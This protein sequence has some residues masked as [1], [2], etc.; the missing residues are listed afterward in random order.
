MLLH[1]PRAVNP[2]NS[3]VGM[4]LPQ[5]YIPIDRRWAMARGAFLVDRT[6]GAALFADISG[7]TLLTDALVRFLGPQRGAEELPRQLNRVYDTVIA[8]VER[9]GGS[10]VGFSGDAITCWF[11]GDT[12]L[13]AAASGLA[14]QEAMEQFR[15]VSIPGGTTVELAIK[16]AVAAG[17]VRRFVV[18]SPDIQLLDVLAG[19][20][21]DRLAIAEHCANR[22]DVVL[23][24]VANANITDYISV[25]K[26]HVNQAD[27]QR[28]AVI[29][30][31][32]TDVPPTPWP[33]LE[34]DTLSE[35]LIRPWL[36]P[37][38][39]DRL[40]SGLGEFLTE[41]RPAVALFVQFGGIDFDNDAFARDKLDAYIRWVQAIL[42]CYG[43]FLIQLT[44]GDKGSYLYAAF[45][46]PI[47]HSD[48]VT[49][50]VASALE[51]RSPPPQLAFITSVRIGVSAGRMRT[52]SYGS[53]TARTYGVLGPEV[54][55][56]ARLM[57]H[58]PSHQVLVS[59]L[60]RKETGDA[61][62]WEELPA[63]RVKGKA[64]PIAV[65]RL[66]GT[67]AQ[68]GV[69]LQEPRY[70]LPIVGRM[71]ELDTVEQRMQLALDQQGQIIALTAEAGM[72]KSRLVAEIIHRASVRGLAVYAGECQSYGTN[73]SYLVWE[74][75]LQVFFGLDRAA[76]IDE[77]V[78]TLEAQLRAIDPDLL[79]RL[80][81]LGMALNLP[82]PDNDLTRS[83]DAKL[84][85]ASLEAL[86]VD[87]VRVRALSTP[88]LLVLE[89]CHWLDPLSHDLLEAVGRAITDVPV[90]IVIAYRPPEVER[91]QAPRVT[92]LVH[93]TVIS[94][95]SFT[96][97]E[98]A[99][100]V[101]LK[102]QQRSGSTAAPPPALIERV[103]ER[104]EGNPFYIEELLNYLYDR[105]VDPHDQLAL[106]QLE[107]PTSLHRL[108][109]SRIDQL[110]E[111]QKLT[112]KVASIIGRLFRLSWLWGVHPELGQRDLVLAD[113][114]SL[115]H[116]DLTPLDQPEPEFTYLFKHIITREVAYESLSFAT[117]ELLHEQ[118]GWFI[119][120]SYSDALDQYIDLL[121]YHYDHSQ[122]VPKRREYLGKAG[123]A[124]QSSFAN[125]AAID[126]YHRL[127]PLLTES[128]Q[129]DVM[130]KLGQVMELIGKWSEA[131]NLY[132]AALE[133]VERTNNRYAQPRCQRAMGELLKKQG[134]Y[135]A[136]AN[137]LDQ[138]RRGFDELHDTVGMGQTFTEIGE[139]YRL[140]GQYADA[141]SSYE[142][143][144]SLVGTADLAVR[145]T[146]LKS[147]GT[148]AWQQG[149]YEAADVFYNESLA[150]HSQ[151]KDKPGIAN[152]LSN[153]GIVAALQNDLASAGNLFNQS[154]TIRRELGDKQGIA[155]SLTNLG[156]VV[157]YQG[158]YATAR[159]LHQ[160][161]LDLYRQLGT[162]KGIADSLTNLANA[163]RDAGALDAARSFYAEAL[164]I[165]RELG[166]QWAIACLL[167]DMSGLAVARAE[168]QQA[169]Q[170]VGAASKLRELIE[171]PLS[172]DEQAKLDRVLEPARKTMEQAVFAS[173]WAEG[174]SLQMDQIVEYVRSEIV[175]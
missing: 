90:L 151:L 83:L 111:S 54:N 169:V 124:A 74:G 2:Y 36:L 130:L 53:S 98:A 104:A 173:T 110:T 101:G 21:I 8:Q 42:Q 137:W 77:Q 16:V 10:V 62:T 48:D 37:A 65:F 41:L 146:A 125:D 25:V 122:N 44:V 60:A 119:E 18:G 126:Y 86:L 127:L 121:A 85:K 100:L 131:Q 47:A 138:A 117:R 23:D 140:Q 157:H 64:E 94:L 80:P 160:E 112:I 33:M 35:A 149:D 69:H 43:G 31:I 136:A 108:I 113:L 52:G 14:I 99:R 141:R 155:T 139:I 56:G 134:E 109:L 170:L 55:M 120:Q 78:Q 24:P 7:F 103:V 133:L 135:V 96:S 116:L 142:K 46:A 162:R 128:E 81:L 39:H 49:R 144:L 6:S 71:P 70:A 61:F 118:L 9:Y 106:A 13:R 123:E 171:T 154:L 148:A 68:R 11:D 1:H 30:R 72:G 105:G 87:C 50:A 22:G 132:H 172:L 93:C 73:N 143:S 82:I 4:E 161:A 92:Q 114:D 158:D 26:W 168:Y 97:E 84:R 40:R 167:E 165:Y 147:A 28:F 45:G 156:R 59:S 102:W 19:A 29:N 66:T 150:I 76:T 63:L 67:Q 75:I 159:V 15:A 145:A 32:T 20:T 174:R 79:P 27:G 89:D 5:T 166:S 57:Q 3:E 175:A 115:S 12:G 34:K 152:L 164:T 107:L 153:L 129:L 58:A 88:F 95:A 38:I 51:L 17:P 163:A 91:L